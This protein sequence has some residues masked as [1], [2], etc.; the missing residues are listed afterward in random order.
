MRPC[1]KCRASAQFATDRRCRPLA[2]V[3]SRTAP[4]PTLSFVTLLDLKDE[5]FDIFE[6]S[7]QLFLKFFQLSNVNN[8]TFLH[9][10]T[11][12]FAEKLRTTQT[13]SVWTEQLFAG[14]FVICHEHLG[15]YHGF[16]AFVFS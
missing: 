1:Q 15:R 14:R 6:P 13:S 4:A 11:M 12:S 7:T 8:M 5:T 2:A 16:E 9:R 10:E 3:R